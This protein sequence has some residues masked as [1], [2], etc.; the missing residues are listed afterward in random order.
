MYTYTST[1]YTKYIKKDIKITLFLKKKIMSNSF[2][3]SLSH[4]V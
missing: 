1:I 4:K 2:C 3:N